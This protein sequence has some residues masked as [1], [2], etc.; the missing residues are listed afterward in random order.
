MFRIFTPELTRAFLFAPIRLDEGFDFSLTL[1]A[2]AGGKAGSPR[3]LRLEGKSLS[4]AGT[5]VRLSDGP[6]SLQIEIQPPTKGAHSLPPLKVT[7]IDEAGTPKVF[8]PSLSELLKLD[9]PPEFKSL[10]AE[11]LRWLQQTAPGMFA[12]AAGKGAAAPAA[13]ESH[14]EAPVEGDER[15]SPPADAPL[16]SY[17]LACDD[18][19]DV[20]FE[21]RVLAAAVQPYRNGRSHAYSVFETRSKRIVAAKTGLSMWP[22]ERSRQEVKVFEKLGSVTDF[23]GFN[24]L[25]KTLYDQLGLKTAVRVD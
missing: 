16:K 6:R 24:T 21:G 8:E 17:V 22:M 10:Y 15:G 14:Y 23:F 13:D 4:P 20:Q 2:S 11:L 18:A 25:A 7:A 5:Q 1:P 12:G 9:L 3:S 19:A